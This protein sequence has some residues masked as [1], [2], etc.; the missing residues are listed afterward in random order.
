MRKKALSLLFVILLILPLA[1]CSAP[2]EMTI[3]QL[4]AS[5]SKYNGEV[6]TVSGYYFHGWET[7]L[8]CEGLKYSG[9]AEGHI[10][11]DGETVWVEGGLPLEVYEKLY[12]SRG[13]LR[14]NQSKRQVRDRWAVWT[15]E[16]PSFPYYAAGSRAPALVAAGSRLNQAYHISI[17]LL[18]S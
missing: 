13:T 10:G 9:L 5:P 17:P 2:A 8:L 12:G 7:V 18:F 3:T 16:R 15:P 6:V 4:M 14:E 1:A 11:P